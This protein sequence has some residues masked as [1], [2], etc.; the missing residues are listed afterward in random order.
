VLRKLGRLAVEDRLAL[1]DVLLHI[2][3]DIEA[4]EQPVLLASVDATSSRS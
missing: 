4:E 3:G 1:R 2:L